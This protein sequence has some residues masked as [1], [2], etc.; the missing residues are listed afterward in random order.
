MELSERVIRTFESEGYSSVYE[1]QDSAGAVYEEQSSATDKAVFV[2]DGS[3]TY[4]LNGRAKELTAP[5]RLDIPANTPH[6]A[7][8]GPN[9]CIMILAE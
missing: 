1:H 3:I 6:S 7:L 8:V 2:T 9:G 4:S 5:K